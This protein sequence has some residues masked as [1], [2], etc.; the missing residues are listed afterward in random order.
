[1]LHLVRRKDHMEN[2][3][4]DGSVILKYFIKN[5]C[6]IEPTEYAFHLF[7]CSSLYVVSD[8]LNLVIISS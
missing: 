8:P 3:S 6:L 1:M 2:Q 5:T 4:A 7:L